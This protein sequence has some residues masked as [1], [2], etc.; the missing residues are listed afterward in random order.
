MEEAPES[1]TKPFTGVST[2]TKSLKKVLNYSNI[3]IYLVFL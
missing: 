3:V 2:K 1:V